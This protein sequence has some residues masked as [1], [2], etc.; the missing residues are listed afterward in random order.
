VRIQERFQLGIDY[1][2]SH[3]VAVLRWPDGRA[4]PLLFDG[5][6]L[7]PSAVYVEADTIVVGRDAVQSARLEPARFEPNP[8][9]RIDDYV[10][11][12]GNREVPVTELIGAALR[13]VAGEARRTS[14]GIPA[15]VTL[16]CPAGWAAPRR[17]V[18]ADA[19]AS[20]GLDGVRLVAEPTAA[21]VYFAEVLGNAVPPGSVVVVHDFG[22]GTFD[23][24][25]VRRTA[26]G[27]E[28]L[29][30]AGSDDLGG[31]DLDALIV[32][33]IVVPAVA[34][35]RLADPSVW[36]RLTGPASVE[37]RRNHRL[38]WDDVRMAKERL[39]RHSAAELIVPLAGT[40]VRITRDEL[41][42]VA[43][44]VV[45][46][47][48]QLTASAIR[49][50]GVP[51]GRI[52]GVFLVGG[53]SRMP[54][55]AHLLHSGLGIA[56]T[57]LEQPEL[58]VAEG[59]VSAPALASPAVPPAVPAVAPV[60]LRQPAVPRPPAPVPI[61]GG[62]SGESA[63]RR[64][65]GWLVGAAGLAVVLVVVGVAYTLRPHRNAA[66][67]PDPS[68]SS[69]AAAGD[70]GRFTTISGVCERLDLTPLKKLMGSP[71]VPPAA[72]SF[73]GT[74]YLRTNCAVHLPGESTGRGFGDLTAEFHLYPGVAKARADYDLI[75]TA[76]GYGER[77]AITGLG[78]QASWQT[79][80]Y[81]FSPPNFCYTCPADH[82]L[83]T[84]FTVQVSN[85]I[86]VVIVEAYY[87]KEAAPEYAPKVRQAIE[88][89]LRALAP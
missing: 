49:D 47:T 25:V 75:K 12:L 73:T 60:T 32:E 87:R 39:S 10:E 84:R 77:A 34:A 69:S 65:S 33:R 43:R 68:G 8:K 23:A 72:S 81:D 22:A 40:A 29:T 35:D 18:L 55:V 42:A 5:S 44:P 70:L 54:L 3:T 13:R 86:V 76:A 83:T 74:E 11:W 57:V 58:V 37:D 80:R 62:P 82:N 31:L 19:A 59:A 6:P 24:S 89:L 27:F 56:P 46:R 9:R 26:T 4:R 30:V 17:Q 41:E 85:V 66:T 67:G 48:V 16:T 71:T 79:K 45:Q 7:L 61:V 64:R 51:A 1:G 63:V 52:A 20:A 53:A 38:F 88:N 78:D 15:D 36:A 14:G 50:C 2:T 21:A 28:V